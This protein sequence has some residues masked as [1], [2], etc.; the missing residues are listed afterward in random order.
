MSVRAFMGDLVIVYIIQ[1]IVSSSDYRLTLKGVRVRVWVVL[2]S[3]YNV[4]HDLMLPYI[5]GAV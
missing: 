2:H 5:F 4:I 3:Y 1:S